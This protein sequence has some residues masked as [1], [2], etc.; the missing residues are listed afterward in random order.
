LNFSFKYQLFFSPF[1]ETRD[2][3]SLTVLPSEVCVSR[4]PRKSSASSRAAERDFA[5]ETARSETARSGRKIIFRFGESE[6]KDRVRAG[7]MRSADRCRYERGRNSIYSATR[8]T[9]RR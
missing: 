5:G 1:R 2:L 9:H 3:S 7:T 8:D 6:K 4:E